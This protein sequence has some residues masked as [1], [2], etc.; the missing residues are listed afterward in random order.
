[1]VLGGGV[2]PRS[3]G[4]KNEPQSGDT[5]YDTDTVGTAQKQAVTRSDDN[6]LRTKPRPF[7]MRI[8]LNACSSEERKA[9][10]KLRFLA[11]G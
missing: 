9:K 8:V 3:R 1:M 11:E 2:S 10:S 6:F 7:D 5:R 4:K